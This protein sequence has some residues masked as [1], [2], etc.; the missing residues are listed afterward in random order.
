MKADRE[1]TKFRDKGQSTLLIGEMRRINREKGGRIVSEEGPSLF[2][3]SLYY[4]LS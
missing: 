3:K 2:S 1:E 4:S